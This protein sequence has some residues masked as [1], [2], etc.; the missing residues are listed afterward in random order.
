[1]KVIPTD[2]GDKV[3]LIVGLSGTGKTTTTFRQQNNSLP[4]QDDIVALVA[5]GGVHSTENGCFAK[6]IGLDP[7]DEPTI[8]GALTRPDA[9]LENVAVD[10]RGKVDFHDDSYTANGRGT[11]ELSVIEHYD[12][13]KL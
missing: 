8:Y 5:G 12:P 13:R 7:D 9:W 10:E 11:F 3:A 1:S 2:Q 6:T 4:V